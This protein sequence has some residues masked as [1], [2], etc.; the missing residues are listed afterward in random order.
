MPSRLCLNCSL[1]C[2]IGLKS[3]DAY[4]GSRTGL[5]ASGVEKVSQTPSV[6]TLR[7]SFNREQNSKSEPLELSNC[8]RHHALAET[9]YQDG[10]F[11]AHRPTVGVCTAW[12][13][14]DGNGTT[15]ILQADV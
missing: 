2:C 8:S 4:W 11:Q 1:K 12:D 14:S 6:Q 9:Q 7:S 13:Q 15:A 5:F 3:S 10:G